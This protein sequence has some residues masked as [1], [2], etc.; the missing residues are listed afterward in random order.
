M[1]LLLC[2]SLYCMLI[3]G[4]DDQIM[5]GDLNFRLDETNLDE[6][7]KGISNGAKSNDYSVLVAKDQL[8]DLINKK[9]L[10]LNYQEA[11]ICFPP[12]FKLEKKEKGMC[13]DFS[14]ME[15]IRCVYKTKAADHSVRIPSYVDRI[16]WH[17]LPGCNELFQVAG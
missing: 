8:Q 11:P 10:F 5:A 7:F 2:L 9:I 14:N 1:G 13:L 6:V 15:D 12:T 3:I 16:I 4:D 17:S